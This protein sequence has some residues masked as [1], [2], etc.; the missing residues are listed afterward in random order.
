LLLALLDRCGLSQV[1]S[2]SGPKRTSRGHC[3]SVVPDPKRSWSLNEIRSGPLDP[4]EFDHLH[5]LAL[6]TDEGD[7]EIHE[8]E[9]S[10]ISDAELREF[11][12]AN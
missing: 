11:E 7:M 9:L 3:K 12:I 4:S 2:L 5:T 6:A 1:R 8:D 10:S